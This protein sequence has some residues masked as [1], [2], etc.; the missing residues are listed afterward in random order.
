[1][2]LVEL[3]NYDKAMYTE[4]DRI[5]QIDYARNEGR[6]EGREEGEK[7]GREEGAS[8]ALKEVALRMKESGADPEYIKQMTGVE[9]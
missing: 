8:E 9:L 4:L 5:A 3:Q 1:M 7:K 6:E 2:S